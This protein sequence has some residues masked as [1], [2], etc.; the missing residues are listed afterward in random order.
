MLMAS[1][2]L[3]KE[4]QEI[5]KNLIETC[6]LQRAVH[7]ARQYG[8]HDIATEISKELAVNGPEIRH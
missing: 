5:A 8:W 3:T 6:G 2:I 1:N 7:A 4:K